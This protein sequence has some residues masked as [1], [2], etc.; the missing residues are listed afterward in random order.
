MDEAAQSAEYV[1]PDE[2]ILAAFNIMPVA[3]LVADG[4]SYTKADMAFI[5]VSAL[6]EAGWLLVGPSEHSDGNVR[7]G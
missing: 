4:Y 2:V 1:A 7:D 5:A 3:L 6:E